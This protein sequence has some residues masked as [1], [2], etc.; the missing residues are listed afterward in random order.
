ME[1]RERTAALTM[2][3][4]LALAAIYFI[5]GS[6]LGKLLPAAAVKYRI[7]GPLAVLTLA[8]AALLPW[9]MTLAMAFS[10]AGDF[11]GAYGSFLFQ[12][13]FFA[14]AHVMLIIYFACRIRQNV[15]IGARPGKAWSA[16]AA[17]IA[18]GLAAFALSSIIPH[19]PAGVIRTGCTVYALLICS[20]FC[21]SMLTRHTVTAAGA[22]LF[23][24]SD[25]IL[26][27]NKFVSPVEYSRWMIMV[28]YYAGQ[29]LIWLGAF[30]HAAEL[31]TSS[32]NI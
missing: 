21:M 29:L 27:W 30:S 25:M 7:I 26:S 23:L 8:G 18:A 24:F 10:L 5:P 16:V 31:R 22:A 28:P 12:M 3:A 15:R 9:Q 1:R 6:L 19:A 32:K 11:S 4:F 13:G 2:A 14:M 20:M 17:L